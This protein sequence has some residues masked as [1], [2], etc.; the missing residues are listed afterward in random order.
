MSET[1]DTDIRALAL[2]GALRW[3]EQQH[4]YGSYFQ[5]ADDVVAAAKAFE[6]FLNPQDT[7]QDAQSS[8]NTAP[9]NIT[10]MG[11]ATTV[12]TLEDFFK[13]LS[14]WA[15]ELI[16]NITSRWFTQRDKDALVHAVL[17]VPAS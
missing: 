11:E 8:E 17:N 13:P 5:N 9:I 4:R 7:A 16:G 10:Y 3:S 12:P 2:D 14:P 1:T 6:G 15:E